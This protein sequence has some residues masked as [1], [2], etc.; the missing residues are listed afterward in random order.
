M[1]PGF[2]FREHAHTA[3]WELEVWAPDLPSLLEQA[4]RGMYTLSGVKL[5]AGTL[6]ERSLQFQALDEE[7]LLVHFLEELLWLEEDEKLGFD[8]FSIKIDP[9]YNLRATLQG[10]RIISLDKEIKAVTYHN[11]VI[12][13]TPQ[14]L[15]TSIVF[16][17]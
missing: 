6:Q 9:E 10:S 17:V 14:G 11:L 7:G 3:D 13:D 4:A 12:Q 16:D 5:Q 15:R 8:H 2:G 1:Q